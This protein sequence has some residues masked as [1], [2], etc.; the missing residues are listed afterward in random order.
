MFRREGG[1]RGEGHGLAVVERVADREGAG[2]GQADDVAGVRRVERFAL[3]GEQ[4]H[5]ARQ[6]H[7]LAGARVADRH[8]ALELAGADAYERDAV[9]M[10]RIHVRLNLEDETR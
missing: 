10:A 4:P 5:R 1:N 6:P 3:V 8:V 2:V 7:V 9:A